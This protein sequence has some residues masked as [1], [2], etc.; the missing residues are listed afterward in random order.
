MADFG[1]K[2]ACKICI[3]ISYN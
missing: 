1:S 3:F 2:L